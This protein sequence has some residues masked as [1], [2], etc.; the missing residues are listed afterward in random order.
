M[1][2]QSFIGG[3]LLSLVIAG[4]IAA[5]VITLLLR[6]RGE[7]A[8]RP[9]AVAASLVALLVALLLLRRTG[10]AVPVAEEVGFWIPAL[11]VRLHFG[12]DGI[13]A[14][15]LATVALV[16]PATLFAAES[17]RPALTTA[18]LLGTEAAAFGAFASLDLFSFLLASQLAMGGA[19]LA[20]GVRGGGRSRAFD[21]VAI[22]L[23][24]SALLLSVA[25]VAGGLFLGTF[26]LVEWYAAAL[27]PH[28]Q[29]LLFSAFAAAFALQGGV[30]LFHGWIGDVAEEATPEAIVLLVAVVVNI[31]LYGLLRFALPLFPAA[32]ALAERTLAL[33]G[34]GGVLFGAGLAV[35]SRTLRQLIAALLVAGTG[36]VLLALSARTTVAAVGAVA[37]AAARTVGLVALLLVADALRR[38]A[39]ADRVEAFVGLGRRAP[40]MALILLLLILALVGIPGFAPFAGLFP[41]LLGAFQ[42]RTVET[43]IA[44]GGLVVIG[45][46]LLI[47]L[48]RMLAVGARTERAIEVPRR[49]WLAPALLV[50][51]LLLAGIA[52]GMLLARV[53][54][55]AEAIVRLG[56]R[57]PALPTALFP[58]GTRLRRAEGGAR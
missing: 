29:L 21:K 17:R 27:P 42:V 34:V 25:V 22:L 53:A 52:P 33:L 37:F 47:V 19:A 7:E 6:G 43:A 15:F 30:L 54:A 2:P 57:P 1:M 11:G 50:L 44:M 4:L 5:A 20:V 28:E 3:H 49:A 51:L 26:D 24:L 35:S 12:V 8:R 58:E 32:A 41:A 46:S 14:L 13:S 9:L 56:N 39:G 23:M 48:A 40:G 18:A 10:S 36:I 31:G 45:V 55:P 38:G 16:L